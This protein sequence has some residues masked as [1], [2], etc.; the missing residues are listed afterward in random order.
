MY[1]TPFGVIRLTALR[2]ADIGLMNRMNHQHS[3]RDAAL[4]VSILAQTRLERLAE[5]QS[6][7]PLA[8]RFRKTSLV[9]RKITERL[10][11]STWK[12]T[13]LIRR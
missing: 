4:E 1:I 7:Y 3:E 6:L 5:A 11:S 10:A 8:H 2:P 13:W 12:N 9:E